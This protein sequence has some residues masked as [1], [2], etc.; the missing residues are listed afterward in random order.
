MKNKTLLAAM[1][2][3]VSTMAFSQD[4]SGN[5][6]DSRQQ[7]ENLKEKINNY[8]VKIDSIVTSEKKKLDKELDVIDKD[9]KE[10]KISESDKKNFRSE[11]AVKYEK[12]INEKVDA[13]KE[14]F[15]EITRE[16]V[17]KSVLGKSAEEKK[18]DMKRLLNNSGFQLGIGFLN[19]T[20]SSEPFNF[21]N[22]PEEIR[23]GQ[24]GSISYQFRFEMQVG[25]YSS[26]VFLNYGLGL[27]ADGYDVNK[28][29]VFAQADGK[30]FQTQFT[31]NS[32]KY[33]QLKSEYIEV[34]LEMQFVLNPKYVDYDGEKFIDDTKTQLRI[35]VGVYGGVK[36]GSRIKYRYSD[37]VT[38][39]NIFK[40][41]VENGMNPFVFGTKLSIGYGGIS[42]FVKK[43][44][45]P[46]FNDDALMNNKNGLQIGVE[47][48]NLTF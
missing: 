47:I 9:F 11:I 45:T 15:E 10:G 34:P 20:N 32:I 8:T 7:Q 27:R 37:E 22:K 21:F 14:S 42:L 29:S 1:L 2:L 38:N 19:L 24:S 18:N 46:I 40:Q 44:L 31:P 16:R 28:S 39:K 6:Q 5:Y 48:F 13:E 30:L 33:S 23:F 41:K 17:R 3:T 43:D 35:G 4:K 12:S 25:K 36:I 26:P